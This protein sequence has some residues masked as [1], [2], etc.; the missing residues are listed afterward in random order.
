MGNSRRVWGIVLL[1]LAALLF[2]INLVSPGDVMFRVGNTNI[3]WIPIVALAIVGVVLLSTASRAADDR[4][5]APPSE[6][7]PT[8]PL[9]DPV[10]TAKNK[11]LESMAWGLFLVMIGG[12]MLVPEE[13]IPKGLWS[14]G[15]GVIFLWLNYARY[16]N[17][18]RMSGF[19]TLLG[20]IAVVGG[21][22]EMA[23]GRDIGGALLLIILGVYV[24][25]KQQFEE[26]QLFGKAE[27]P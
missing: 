16:R 7:A 25:F 26:A 15:V 21:V 12:M 9:K 2:V 11:N 13:V 20:I 17:K 4:P 10:K 23:S 18:I 3:P 5:A 19:T 1:A 24:V 22:V 27:E 8:A 14:I 6:T